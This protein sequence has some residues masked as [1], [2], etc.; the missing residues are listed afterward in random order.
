MTKRAPSA[1]D[2]KLCKRLPK[3]LPQI[4]LRH[5][6]AVWV[7]TEL[8]F[9]GSVSEKTFYEYLKS[10][11][12]LG[13]PFEHPPGGTTRRG[14]AR[15]TYCHLMELALALT[16]RVYHVVPDTLLSGIMHYRE[17]LYHYYQRAYL[18]RLSGRG[19][20]IA[21]RTAGGFVICVRGTFLDLQVNY[22]AG[23]LVSFGPPKSLSPLA[24]LAKF[25]EH[26]PTAR[27]SLPINLS[28]LAEKVVAAAL[29]AP[30]THRDPPRP[31]RHGT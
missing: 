26:E 19:T 24:A 4:E 20:P 11:R 7:M 12:K 6:Q 13:I 27:V 28:L 31:E 5:G 22:S 18:E 14:A 3:A 10:L 30:P 1:P 17:A 2:K 25:A 29:Q 21:L 9:R 16:L 8:G 15:Y 23:H